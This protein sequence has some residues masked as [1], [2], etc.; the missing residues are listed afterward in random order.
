[1]K[2]VILHG[3]YGACGENRQQAKSINISDGFF[4]SIFCIHFVGGAERSLG[5]GEVL[6]FGARHALFSS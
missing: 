4:R 5:I 2:G 1:L 6:R 3:G